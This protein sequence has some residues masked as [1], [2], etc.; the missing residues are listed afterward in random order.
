MTKKE[1]TDCSDNEKNLDEPK[2]TTYERDELTLEVAL[3]LQG[4]AVRSDRNIK[5]NFLRVDPRQ[6]LRVI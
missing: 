2:V 3:T 6:I 1:R 4:S 5:E